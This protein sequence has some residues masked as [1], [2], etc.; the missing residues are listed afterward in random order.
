MVQSPKKTFFHRLLRNYDYRLPKSLIAQKPAR[1]RDNA[2]LL[3]YDRRTKKTNY[4]RFINLSKYLPKNSVLVFNQTKVIPARLVV[5]K[6]TGGKVEI[7]YIGRE[8]NFIKIL[9][10]K[11]VTIGS[12]L[13]IDGR[14]NLEFKVFKKINNQYLLKPNFS[15]SKLQKIFLTCGKTPLPPYLKHSPLT[16]NQRRKLYQTI[17]AKAG[18]SVAAPTASLHFTNRLLKKLKK[19]R[20][21]INFIHLNVNLGTFAPLTE[22]NLKTGRLHTEIYQIDSK[23]AKSI[24]TAKKHKR[25]IIAV[26]TTVVRALESAAANGKLR[27]FSGKTTLFITP[28]FK[29]QIVDGLVTNFHVPQS[30]LMMLVAALVGKKRLLQLY[31]D[32]IDRRMKFFSFGDGMLI[33]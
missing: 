27:R 24:N 2:R 11:K 6:P 21:A 10:N 7:L 25:P 1:P 31:H 4:D 20:V 30:S 12:I 23:T 18:E 26:G 8:Q 28:G 29:F 17:F 16:E 19:H 13:K 32:A 3:I 33:L 22:Q 14:H 5:T 9:A 15:L